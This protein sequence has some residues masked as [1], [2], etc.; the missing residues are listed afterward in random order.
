MPPRLLMLPN[1]AASKSAAVHVC[2]PACLAAASVPSWPAT[3]TS[4]AGMPSASLT[5]CARVGRPESRRKNRGALRNSNF[6][7]LT[8]YRK[9]RRGKDRVLL[10]L[11]VEVPLR[12]DGP[13]AWD[14]KD[15]VAL[16]ASAACLADIAEQQ[17]KNSTV[18]ELGKASV[19]RLA[20]TFC[21]DRLFL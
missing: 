8:V 15:A 12:T 14:I 20:S 21:H 7:V 3:P 11:L 17:C 4:G 13:R 18:V 2:G 1:S 5:K 16:A 10:A 19:E 6:S 9:A